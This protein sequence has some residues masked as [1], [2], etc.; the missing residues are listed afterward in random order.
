MHYHQINT[1][2]DNRVRS[3]F[4]LTRAQLGELLAQVLP[5]LAEYR[6]K[7][8]ASRAGRKRAPG[9]GRKRVLAPYQEVLITLVYLRHNVSHAVCGQLFGVCAD[10]SEDTFSDV[11]QV[12]KQVCPSERYDAEK[13]WKKGEPSWSPSAEDL[14]L[15]D[16]FETPVPRPS[17]N[18]KQKRLYSGKKKRHTLKTQVTTNVCGEIICIDPG[19]PGP[20]NDKTLYEKSGVEKRFPDAPK[21]ADLGYLGA[22]NMILPHKR[23]N[24]RNVRNELTDE[25]KEE[26]RRL[27]SVRVHVE[28]AIRRIKG[29]RIMRGEYRLATGLF[30]TVAQATVGLVQLARICPQASG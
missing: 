26:N 9:A 30:P 23:K 22:P 2:T 7:Q 16:S 3:L 6:Q 5:R 17:T 29:W 28:H 10:V 14:L 27:A 1:F 8:L 25:Q 19:H 4:G 13:R 12:L 24:R 21:Q 15:V 20:T 11:V 18:E